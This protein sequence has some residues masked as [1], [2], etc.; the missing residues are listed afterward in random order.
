ML[1]P[2]VK[3][4]SAVHET[5]VWSLGEKDPLEKG[6][7]PPFNI[8]AWRIPW[9]EDHGGYGPWGWKESDTT[10]RLTLHDAELGSW[11]SEVLIGL[12]VAPSS[13]CVIMPSGPRKEDTY[14]GLWIKGFSDP[15]WRRQWHPAPVLLPRKFHGRRSL[16]GCSPWGREESDTTE[17]LPFYFSLSSIGEGNGNPLQR[18]CLENPRDGGIWWAS[19]YGVAQSRTWLK[20]QQQQENPNVRQQMNGWDFPDGPVIKNPCSNSGDMG[21][22]P[23]WG[24]KIPYTTGQVSPHT[25]TR[26]ACVLQWRTST[27]KNNSRKSNPPKNVRLYKEKT[28]TDE[29][30]KKV[31]HTH[32]NTIQP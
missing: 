19:V 28:K 16:V 23:G 12:S 32:G 11:I 31:S 2:K 14:P 13:S 26:E 4:L 25:T 5:R 30:V 10:E 18:S 9:T 21:L 29:W 7:A 1:A 20:Q 6:M 27:T 8:L 24:T 3:N 17:R 22:I 15:K